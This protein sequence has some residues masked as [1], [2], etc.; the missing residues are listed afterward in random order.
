[1]ALLCL[2]K[3]LFSTMHRFRPTFRG[4]PCIAGE[5]DIVLQSSKTLSFGVEGN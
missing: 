3:A 1:M 5:V 4:V 2:T